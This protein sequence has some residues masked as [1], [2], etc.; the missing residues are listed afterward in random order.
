MVDWAV[1]TAVED[2]NLD[3]LVSVGELEAVL[4]VTVLA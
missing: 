2:V 1:T 3:V 4:E